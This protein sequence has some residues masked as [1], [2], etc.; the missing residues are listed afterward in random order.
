MDSEAEAAP[1]ETLPK[2]GRDPA[3]VTK[4]IK[5]YYITCFEDNMVLVDTIGLG[6][7]EKGLGS[8]IGG[9]RSVIQNQHC[10]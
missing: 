7:L 8:L 5:S 3:G 6:D 4:A 10:Q 1:I 2:T 9:I